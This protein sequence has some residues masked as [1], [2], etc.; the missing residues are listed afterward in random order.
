MIYFNFIVVFRYI[1]LLL[2]SRV[3]QVCISIAEKH[4]QSVD[5][6]KTGR[7]PKPLLKDWGTREDGKIMPPERPE[8]WPDFMCKNHEP[9]YVSTR[10]VGQLFRYLL[11]FFPF[12][13]KLPKLIGSY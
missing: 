9:S 12:L 5:F 1:I 2:F 11:I 10:L 4:S 3:L 8:H 6:P 7:P 13:K